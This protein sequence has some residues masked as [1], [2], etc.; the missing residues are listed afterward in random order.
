MLSA[1]RGVPPFHAGRDISP[2]LLRK[3][4]QDIG[5]TPEQ[6]E[7]CIGAE[8]RT[9]EPAQPASEGRRITARAMSTNGPSGPGAGASGAVPKEP[10]GRPPPDESPSA[11]EKRAALDQVLQS[12][13][14]VRADQLRSFL[15]YVS[16][17][18]LGGRGSEL[19]EHLIGVEALGRPPAYSTTDDS[20]VRRCAHT[21]RLK[22]EEAYATDLAQAR[23]RIELPRGGY[24]PRFHVA[25][26]AAPA[27]GATEGILPSATRFGLPWLLVAFALGALAGA[28]ALR[29]SLR[30]ANARLDPVV[31]EAWGPLAR[32]G[33]KPLICLSAPPHYGVLAYPEGP[34]PPKVVP[35]PDALDVTGWWIRHY[36]LPPGYRLATHITSGPIRLGEVFGLVSALRTLDRLGLE[37]EV[38]AEK[39][40]MLPALRGRNLLLFGNP[41]YSHATARLL[42]RAPW[43]VAYDVSYRDRVVRSNGQTNAKVF[44]PTRDELG[45]VTGA[46]G[47]ITV[48]PSEGASGEAPLGT[49]IISCTNAGGCQAAMEFLSSPGS[50]RDFQARLRQEGLPGFPPAYQVVIRPRV[51]QSAPVTPGDYEAHVVFQP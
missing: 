31:A 1:N 13:E 33:A 40:V 12:A 49:I 19:N 28:G 11:E 7:A 35:L 32:P 2:T 48:L 45:A 16:E 34:L 44:T 6:L 50:L 39:Y 37:P 26:P 25:E 29:F 43:T 36:P 46:L 5:L 38:V 42:E 15:R 14:F 20:S 51:F 3:I 18:E 30:P 8:R 47:L 22:L 27:N 17:M 23:V 24:Q 9:K 10:N 4:A 21:L 41:E